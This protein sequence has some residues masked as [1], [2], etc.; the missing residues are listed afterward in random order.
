MRGR[1]AGGGPGWSDHDHF[2]DTFTRFAPIAGY[3]PGRVLAEVRT[4]AAAD[5]VTYL[6]TQTNPPA[7]GEAA[8][9]ATAW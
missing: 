3:A 1:V 5:N 7:M 4:L 8:A 9:L 2:F 6:E